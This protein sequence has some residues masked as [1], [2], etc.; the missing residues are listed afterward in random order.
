MLNLWWPEGALYYSPIVYLSTRPPSG[1][2]LK[3]IGSA[4]KLFGDRCSALDRLFCSYYLRDSWR[5]SNPCLHIVCRDVPDVSITFLSL[6][7]GSIC[8]LSHFHGTF[9]SKCHDMQLAFNVAINH[10]HESMSDSKSQ[11]TTWKQK[12]M[13]SLCS[14]SKFTCSQVHLFVPSTI[15][16]KTG[17]GLHCHSRWHPVP[18]V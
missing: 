15:L 16:V 13:M 12:Y 1:L 2:K 6:K 4:N 8:M 5:Q 3:F 9:E 7:E 18:I 14:L 17:V 10:S 11:M